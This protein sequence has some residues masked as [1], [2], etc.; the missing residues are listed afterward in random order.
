MFRFTIREVVLLTVIVA[1]G[2][3]WCLDRTGRYYF[4]ESKA[5]F[6]KRCAVA[7]QGQLERDGYKVHVGHERGINIVDP[8]GMGTYQTGETGRGI[9]GLDPSA[10]WPT[11]DELDAR[12]L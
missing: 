4:A 9:L 12:E 1:M 8:A 7:F 10:A 6:W 11:A 3:G 2:L 5:A